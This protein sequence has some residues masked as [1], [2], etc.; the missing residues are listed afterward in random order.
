MNKKF[1]FMVAALLAAGT[2]AFAEGT[3]LET[4]QINKDQIKG[5]YYYLV[6]EKETSGASTDDNVLASSLADD[7]LSYSTDDL[8]SSI[9]AETADKYLWKVTA[10]EVTEGDAKVTKLTLVNKATGKTLAYNPYTKQFV[11]DVE[12][13][14]TVG[15]L[16][17]EFKL[18]SDGE[19]EV[20][21]NLELTS[22]KTGEDDSNSVLSA[23][24]S[25]IYL[26]KP[27]S[28]PCDV[29][30]L[31]DKLGAGF[32]LSF[33]GTPEGKDN[34]SNLTIVTVS[35]SSSTGVNTSNSF[36]LM[37]S[38]NA[39]AD[40]SFDLSDEDSKKAFEAAKFIVLNT[41][42]QEVTGSVS[43]GTGYAYTVVEG[44]NLIATPTAT[45]TESEFV[46]VEAGKYPAVNAQFTAAESVNEEG[47]LQLKHVDGVLF[48]REDGK[49][50]N[51]DD[52]EDLNE[53][54]GLAVGIAGTGNKV[55]SSVL[56]DDA[57]W[58]T[59]GLGTAV[60][61]KDVVK[62]KKLVYVTTTA[63][64]NSSKFD[65]I[66]YATGT[67][68]SAITSSSEK[69][70]KEKA[71]LTSQWFLSANADNSINLINRE[72]GTT[73]EGVKL[74][75]TPGAAGV[76]TVKAT[77][78]TGGTTINAKYL[79][80]VDVEGATAYDG[81]LNLSADELKNE[82]TI[83]SV[84]KLADDS[85]FEL[86]VVL[87]Q[88]DDNII[89]VTDAEKALKFKFAHAT[90]PSEEDEE[91]SVVDTL[92]NIVNYNYYDAGKLKAASD[93]LKVFK[94]NILPQNAEKDGDDPRNIVV[95]S[96]NA[97]NMV[98]NEDDLEGVTSVVF[99]K[100]GD[101]LVMRVP[102]ASVSA[103]LSATNNYLGYD[104]SSSDASIMVNKGAVNALSISLNAVEVAPTYKLPES[105]F[106]LEIGGAYLGANAKETGI[107]TNDT[108]MLKSTDVDSS[109]SF[110][111]FSADKEETTTPSYYLSTNG[112]MMYNPADSIKKL[113][114]E[115]DALSDVFQAD[116]IAAKYEEKAQ[117]VNG[118]PK[119][120]DEALVKFQQAKYV[121]ADS[122]YVVEK[123]ING[124]ALKPFKFQA[125]ETDGAVS[126]KNGDK[127]VAVVNGVAVLRAKDDAA[128]FN[129]VA[130]EAPTSNESVSASEVAVVAQNGS[131][132]VKNAAGKNVVVSTI[133]GQVVANEVLTSDNATIN[134][135]A[136][137]VVV[138]VEGESFKVNVK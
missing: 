14:T 6:L 96:T 95:T 111:A 34:F 110:Y 114:E 12:E 19:L 82:Y 53:V 45:D 74:Y 49:T 101:K 42:K 84:A 113:N 115:I 75:T 61:V 7:V 23:I 27:A 37:V 16:V 132:V 108:T 117:Y 100:E 44:K 54:D 105:H 13:Y 77:G 90:K 104:A 127:Y 3:A 87:A 71:Y 1:T 88:N 36:Y 76:Y 134:V 22:N 8:Y 35:K 135:P 133:L 26:V 60:D 93:T 65:Y 68:T 83:S 126:L 5:E 72:L 138:A 20:A 119:N 10:K 4:T 98:K 64:E 39:G 107:L 103:T 11:A 9:T 69:T 112:K 116:K 125:E 85:N 15:N 63:D 136:G 124:D 109:F 56:A 86:D 21:E 43:D 67:E 70:L 131:V 32:S 94:Y 46:K 52:S 91:V 59:Y 57:A 33:E 99:R 62:G 102:A 38:G 97:L 25:D 31:Q 89:P 24:G 81:Y 28:T 73:I 48:P 50:W 128:K 80:F 47:K 121:D 40:N 137:I 123:G 30:D 120:T 2:S 66:L 29:E 130:A 18:N 78:T 92:Y 17:K 41:T 58:L 79:K 51:K 122:L 118:D 129:L 106:A 55:V